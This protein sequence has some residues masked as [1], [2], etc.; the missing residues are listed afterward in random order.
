MPAN[1][2]TA[3]SLSLI[4]SSCGHAN[5]ACATLGQRHIRIY[6]SAPPEGNKSSCAPINAHLN[7]SFHANAQI[8]HSDTE[9]RLRT[10]LNRC[11]VCLF[12][13][14]TTTKWSLKVVRR[15]PRR[16][17]PRR[18]HRRPPCKS[19]RSTNLWVP[20]RPEATTATPSLGVR[21]LIVF[22]AIRIINISFLASALRD[23][24]FIDFRITRKVFLPHS[25][26]VVF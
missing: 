17:P 6:E 5:A 8:S 9:A 25:L 23:G 21:A 3:R 10:K 4:L 7:T 15:R 19:S 16:P 26:S 18:A 20:P 14:C 2:N 12:A 11:F 13:G 24:N 22:S 1:N